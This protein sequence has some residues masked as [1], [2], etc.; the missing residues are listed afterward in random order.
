MLNNQ[1]SPNLL[2]LQY[3]HRTC[4]K[5]LSF[6]HHLT[7][8]LAK[9]GP[10]GPSLRRRN[11]PKFQTLVLN[12]PATRETAG[13]LG[14]CKITPACFRWKLKVG[15]NMES[16]GKFGRWA[17]VLL[18]TSNDKKPRI[19]TNHWAYCSCCFCFELQ[20][21]T[22]MPQGISVTIA[23]LKVLHWWFKTVFLNL[24]IVFSQ[25]LN[26][27]KYVFEFFQSSYNYFQLL[28][29]R[30][31]LYL[32]CWPLFELAGWLLRKVICS[33]P[34]G[35]RIGFPPKLKGM[36][37]W[38][39]FTLQSTKM[40]G[41]K[42]IICLIGVA[43][44]NWCFTMVQ[45]CMNSDSSGN[46]TTGRTLDSSTSSTFASG[47]HN[48]L[49]LPSLPLSLRICM[50]RPGIAAFF[51]HGMNDCL[52]RCQSHIIV[53]R[54]HVDPWCVFCPWFGSVCCKLADLG[55]GTF[56]ISFWN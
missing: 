38:F 5:S 21:P 47:V 18:L 46:H 17:T 12:K 25:A 42:I 3:L 54:L 23:D 32:V 11:E 37:K 36:K 56:Q 1:I 2:F 31:K 6:F 39:A 13:P 45:R 43:S 29:F 14:G 7:M 27:E 35:S 20:K 26:L 15:R 55:F 52:F 4:C 41:W 44:S 34:F 22:M 53:Y 16:F 28:L 10:P 24:F 40:A 50:W 51:L 48:A 19:P 49:Q 33:M 9:R 8:D 30:L